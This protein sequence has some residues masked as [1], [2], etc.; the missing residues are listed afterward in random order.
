MS[1]A[2]NPNSKI[3]TDTLDGF[4]FLTPSIVVLKS[5]LNTF[6]LKE[7]LVILTALLLWNNVTFIEKLQRGRVPTYPSSSFPNDS[8]LHNITHLSK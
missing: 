2:L 4:Y 5:H 1:F 6:A 3:L 7:L 8:I